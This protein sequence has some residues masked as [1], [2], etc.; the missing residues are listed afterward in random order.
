M[1]T[2]TFDFGEQVFLRTMCSRQDAFLRRLA[3]HPRPWSE[4]PLIDNYRFTNVYR[5][6]DRNSQYL[7]KNVIWKGSDSTIEQFYR[8]LLFRLFN[9]ITTWDTF[10]EAS[11]LIWAEHDH[12]YL[13]KVIDSITDAKEPLFTASYS[14]PQ[15]GALHVYPG[16]TT[17]HRM[18]GL[19]ERILQSDILDKIFHAEN[20]KEIVAALKIAP[21]IGDFLGNQIALDFTYTQWGKKFATDDWTVPG[22]GAVSGLKLI[23][24]SKAGLSTLETLQ[25]FHSS[26]PAGLERYG[27]T[28]N[29]LQTWP[30]SI[31]DTEHWICETWKYIRLSAIYLAN[32]SSAKGGRSTKQFEPIGVLESPVT[33]W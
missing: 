12:G 27:L 10:S 18:I 23:Y 24:N 7:I 19:I 16:T 25:H 11:E 5:L 15:T 33:P 8:I 4:D 32:G 3:G 30:F 31:S 17:A 26:I 28:F 20:M 13:I 21:G 1:A 6:L 22:P 2:P 29:G 14:S 9:R